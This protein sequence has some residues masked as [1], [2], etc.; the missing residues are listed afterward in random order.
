MFLAEPMIPFANVP[1]WYWHSIDVTKF[2]TNNR[3][4]LLPNLWALWGDGTSPIIIF[5]SSQCIALEFTWQQATIYVAAVYASNSYI[6]RRQLW[7]DLTH[8]QG[9]FPGPWLFIGD[10]NVVMGAHEKRGC[11]PPLAS[12]CLDFVHWTNAN[13][14]THL[15][16]TVPLFTWHNGRFGLEN[17][18]LRLDR[19][20]CNDGWISLW[21]RT[22][23]CAL[24]RHQ[25]D[26]H[27][28]LLS[29]DVALVK[30][31][32]PFKFFKTWTT[33]EDCRELVSSNWSNP[34][35][36]SGMLRLQL[37]LKSLKQVFKVWN[38]T[39]FGDVDRQVRLAIDEVNRIQILIDTAGFT[40]DLYAQDLNAQLILTRALNYQDLLWKE[41][42]RDQSFING[43]RNTAYF[44]KLAK[45]RAATKPITLLYDSHTTITEQT[46]IEQHVL[47]YFQNIFSVDNNCI[48]SNL[49]SRTIPSV[50]SEEDN[51]ALLRL[52]LRD[53]IKS[54]IF[55][56][57][58]D[59]APG[60]DGFGGHFFQTFWDI[61]APDVIQS[62]Q[63]FFITGVLAPNLNSNLIVLILKVTG[64][65]VMGDF[66]PIA[67]TNFQFK[68]ITKILADRLAPITMRIISIEQRGFIR[69]R[70]I[71]ECVILASEAI[72]VIDKRQF[73]G[74]MALKVDIKKA[75]DTLDWNFLIAVL[76]QFGFSSVFSDWILAILQ[77]AR[78]SIL[79]NGKA[80]GFFSCSRGVRQG[81]PLS[82]LL[83]CIAEAVLSRALS[84]ARNTGKIVPMSYS[85]G[86][87]IPTHI[88]YADDVM[89]FCAGTKQNIRCLL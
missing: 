66:W 4:D 10:F 42:A 43:D 59:G 54:A 30:H 47:H 22:S 70:N 33:H 35:R 16:T 18:A 46:D 61:V 51:N 12:A 1:A 84:L 62:V 7:A 60:P 13:H 21:D 64:A 50:V 77:S 39:V 52:P 45:F 29:A 5:M 41:K 49:V 75:F 37:K 14:L 79:V 71:A 38:R 20:I 63:D 53:E 65:Q 87:S 89:I 69:E 25:S 26:H 2:C 23:C 44:H 82:P 55:D 15:P 86:V 57:N 6:S 74:N 19:S 67:L 31:A 56:L 32:V 78:L 72:N 27:P 34:I 24:A 68:I 40:D 8:L 88:L 73:G 83:F 48:T 81:D 76:R 28:L 3:D 36:G 9:C 11:R 80:V 85:R 17:V 58:G